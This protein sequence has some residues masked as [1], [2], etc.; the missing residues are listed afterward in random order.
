MGSKPF[1][2]KQFSVAQNHCTHKV[3]TDGVLLGA[4][5]NIDEADKSVLDIGTGSGLIALMLA[6]RT[7]SET[8]I[9]ALEIESMAAEQAK[10][11]VLQS[12][13]PQK[14]RV[15]N[16]SLQ[17][18]KPETKYD[19]IISNPPYFENSLRPPEKKRTQAR[20]TEQL[21]YNDLLQHADRLLTQRGRLAVILPHAGGLR[22][23]E[24]ARSLKLIPIRSANFRS[25]ADK[26]VERLLL[27]LAYEV[28]PQTVTEIVLH[29]RDEAW[30][31]QYKRLTGE[32]YLKS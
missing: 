2:F 15:H 5:V 20:H 8:R 3:G 4:W 26:P 10:E 7:N 28:N 22:F 6:Q 30:S 13:W 23:M 1:Q 11:N 32:F 31:D 19:L 14:I 25:R 18:F 29:S 27:E 21:R 12:P 16:D 24:Q 9:D 17:Q